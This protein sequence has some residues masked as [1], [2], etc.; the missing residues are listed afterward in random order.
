MHIGEGLSM[1]NVSWVWKETAEILGVLG[2]IG[3]LIF[4]ALEVRQGTAAV[5]S[6]TI[7]SISQQSFTTVALII[8]NADL[9]TALRA[10]SDGMPL[11][12]D[13]EQLVDT[14]WNAA[15]RTQQNRFLQIELG[16]LSEEIAVEG[17][18]PGTYGESFTDHWANVR[19]RYPINFQEYIER[20]VLSSER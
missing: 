11:T 16:I 3:S 5:R 4:V 14:F 2:V 19:D 20:L 18:G 15:L 1:A 12:D 9:R 10:E 17:I 13:Q 7:Q 8:E 6:S